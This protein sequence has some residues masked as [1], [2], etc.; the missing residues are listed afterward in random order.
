MQ[1]MEENNV[2]IICCLLRAFPA[3]S[4]SIIRQ[5]ETFFPLSLSGES[6]SLSERVAGAADFRN[7]VCKVCE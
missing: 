7:V 3:L 6:L 2:K 4:L 5:R 1:P